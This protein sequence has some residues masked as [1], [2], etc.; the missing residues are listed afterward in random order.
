MEKSTESYFRK[1]KWFRRT[2]ATSTF[3]L[4]SRLSSRDL[5]RDLGELSPFSPCSSPAPSNALHRMRSMRNTTAPALDNE[6]LAT[7]TLSWF[8][9]DE[10]CTM[11]MTCHQ[12][13]GMAFIGIA[14]C[15]ATPHQRNTRHRLLFLSTSQVRDA[16]ML[17]CVASFQPLACAHHSPTMLAACVDG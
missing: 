1:P 15:L 4:S 5:T 7:V 3:R 9:V 13:H 10:V 8:I 6:Y 16:Q 2:F 17:R 11:I 12:H 14:S